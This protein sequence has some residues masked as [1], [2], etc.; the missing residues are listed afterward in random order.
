[1]T[2]ATWATALLLVAGADAPKASPSSPAAAPNQAVA[3]IAVPAPPPPEKDA[4]ALAL[5]KKMSERL[6][7]A[8][9]F[10]LKARVSLELPVGGGALATFVNDASVA[11]QRP[12]KL[13]ASRAG[14]LPEFR[15]AYDGKSMTVVD[16]GK[17]LWGT[18]AAPPTIDAMLVAAGEQ[19]DLSF[20]FD[21]LLVADPFAVIT[22]NLTQASLV[23]QS[24]VGG[25]RTD[26]VVLASPSMELQLW[27]DPATG[28]PARAVVVY[29]DHPLRPHFA[30]DY[31]D[32]KL[33]PELPASTFA[34]P[35][36][37][38]ATQVPFRA[39][40]GAFR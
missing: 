32:W 16:P 20:P 34:L 31:S 15:F 8:K 19:G 12:G 30:A 11:L 25:T 35:R 18:T 17:G 21:E 27:V 40:A 28:L 23:G 3:V 13:A 37:A 6:Q 1:M 38:G 33:D 10:T 7:G 14:D 29:A 39:A 26:H 22:R 4:R 9:A 24:T 36:P 5:V 2:L